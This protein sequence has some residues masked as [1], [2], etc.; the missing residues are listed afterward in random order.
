MLIGPRVCFCESF[1]STLDTSCV[2]SGIESHHYAQPLKSIYKLCVCICVCDCVCMSRC[3]SYSQVILVWNDSLV[4]PGYTF[5]F[6]TCC[7]LRWWCDRRT[8]RHA[9]VGRFPLQKSHACARCAIILFR[10][11]KNLWLTHARLRETKNMLPLGETFLFPLSSHSRCEIERAGRK[12]LNF[13]SNFKISH[14]RIY[15]PFFVSLSLCFQLTSQEKKINF[16]TSK[17]KVKKSI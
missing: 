16:A 10:F 2:Y 13:C 9:F 4:P 12:K 1:F 8:G 14:A 5:S 6:Y 15:A 11:M 7:N 17:I 3:D